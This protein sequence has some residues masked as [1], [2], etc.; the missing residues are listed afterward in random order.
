MD[1]APISAAAPARPADR[2]DPMLAAALLLDVPPEARHTLWRGLTRAMEG[3]LWLWE[4][5]PTSRREPPP[6]ALRHLGRPYF[7]S[8]ALHQ[9]TL[10]GVHRLLRLELPLTVDVLETLLF[11]SEGDAC[12]L[13]AEQCVRVGQLYAEL[14]R[15]AGEVMALLIL[16]WELRLLRYRASSVVA[17]L[18]FSWGVGIPA[19]AV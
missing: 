13:L 10:E 8:C 6:L 5:A 17:P 14:K 4:A 11:A 7:N 12:S 1:C 15:R 2:L 16:Q 3:A 9:Q 18:V 19:S